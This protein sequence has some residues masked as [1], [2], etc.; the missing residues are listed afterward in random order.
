MKIKG[1]MSCGPCACCHTQRSLEVDE[2]CDELLILCVQHRSIDQKRTWHS[3]GLLFLRRPINE[4]LRMSRIIQLWW[5]FSLVWPLQSPRWPSLIFDQHLCCWLEAANNLSEAP[6]FIIRIIN[7]RLE[8]ICW[9]VCLSCALF[10][11][12]HHDLHF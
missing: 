5:S 10:L 12:P 7:G 1:R 11:S 3:F 8:S 6:G 9:S 2:E 4:N